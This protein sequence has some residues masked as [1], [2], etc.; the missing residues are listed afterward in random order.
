[1]SGAP[2][3]RSSSRLRHLVSAR[4]RTDGRPGSG[5]RSAARRASGR[6]YRRQTASCRWGTAS[7]CDS[8][9]VCQGCCDAVGRDGIAVVCGCGF[10]GARGR[11]EVVP[12][13]AIRHDGP[14]GAL[15]APGWGVEGTTRR[16]RLFGMGDAFRAHSAQGVCGAR[17]GVQSG[18]LRSPGLDFAR[19]GCRYEVLRH[20][21]EAP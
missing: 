21:V 1:M 18:S 8:K 9:R 7:E 19:A 12:R 13:G 6:R 20:H 3:H 11:Q 17:D 2:G 5:G 15:F 4:H 10:A 16:T 14:L